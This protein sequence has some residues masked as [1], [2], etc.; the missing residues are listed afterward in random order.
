[1][2]DVK[3]AVR[4]SVG[5]SSTACVEKVMMNAAVSSQIF[6]DFTLFLSVQIV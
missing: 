2:V 3:V 6:L 4:F 5:V 1:M